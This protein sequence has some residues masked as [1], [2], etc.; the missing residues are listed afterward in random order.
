ME[1]G[2]LKRMT[3]DQEAKRQIA[4]LSQGLSALYALAGITRG[5]IFF[6]RTNVQYV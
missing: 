2:C 4:Q 1:K 5:A 3:I 6:P